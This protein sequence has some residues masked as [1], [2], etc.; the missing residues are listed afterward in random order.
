MG[1]RCPMLTAF[2]CAAV[3]SLAF[4]GFVPLQCEPH[5]MVPEIFQVSHSQFLDFQT[6]GKKSLLDLCRVLL[7]YVAEGMCV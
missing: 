4:P 3:R 6:L 1:K 7:L 2:G 5:Y